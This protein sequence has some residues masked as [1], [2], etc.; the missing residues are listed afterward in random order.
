MGCSEPPHSL[1]GS[2]APQPARALQEAI[3][4]LSVGPS[5]LA[6]PPGRE[7]EPPPASEVPRP[8]AAAQR[9]PL[10]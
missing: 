9:A 4:T 10:G 3:S 6:E 1:D 8:W 7:L 2:Q 5:P